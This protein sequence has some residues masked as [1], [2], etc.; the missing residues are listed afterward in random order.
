MIIDPR[1]PQITALGLELPEQ[2]PEEVAIVYQNKMKTG[3]LTIPVSLQMALDNLQPEDCS[4][5]NGSSIGYTVPVSSQLVTAPSIGSERESQMPLQYE[6]RPPCLDD[7]EQHWDGEELRRLL[8]MNVHLLNCQQ[9]VSQKLIMLDKMFPTI[10]V[11]NLETALQSLL[12]YSQ[13]FLEVVT[14][15][16][17]REITF[18]TNGATSR[19]ET[20]FVSQAWFDIHISLVLAIINCYACLMGSYHLIFSYLLKELIACSPQ[21]SPT[22]PNFTFPTLLTDGE[23]SRKLQLRLI[24]NN[25]I[26]ML[27]R[28]EAG[29]GLPEQYSVACLPGQSRHH[30]GILRSPSAMVFLD[31]LTSQGFR[32]Y[33]NGPA[34][35]KKSSKEIVQAIHQFLGPAA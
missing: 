5:M 7:Q 11:N 3:G 19:P 12:D 8:D 32:L 1:Q 25:G 6:D 33:V 13:Q 15:S 23:P 16:I 18:T 22:F 31:N 21:P 2:S 26:R 24:F 30:D 20:V 10:A 17:L 14:F 4:S 27:A 28:L 34:T 9:I 29:L 35:G